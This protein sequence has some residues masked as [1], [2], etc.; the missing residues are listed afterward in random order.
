MQTGTLQVQQF[1]GVWFIGPREGS[2]DVFAR[3][4]TTTIDVYKILAE[5]HALEFEATNGAKG[6]QVS[7]VIPR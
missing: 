5:G 1:E 7:R 3:Y 4:S 2:S 6:M